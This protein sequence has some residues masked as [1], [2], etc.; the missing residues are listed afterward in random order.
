MH[1]FRDIFYLFFPEVCL[2][3][4]KPLTINEKKICVQCS[5][6]LPVTNFTEE[7]NNLVEQSFYGRVDIQ[8]ASCLFYY[9][10]KSM[11][12]QLVHKLKY[13]NEEQLGTFFGQW[14]GSELAE[15]KRLP[16]IDIVVPVPIH[17]K[18]LKT[19][20]Y[21]Q[22]AKFSQEIAKSIKADYN[23]ENL[24][25]ISDV[26]TQTHKNRADRW[27]N[28][29]EKFSLIDTHLFENKSVLLVDDV[30]T[31]GATI[32]ACALQLQKAKNIKISVVTIAFTS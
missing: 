15:S 6:D 21:N 20:G 2:V 31:T 29:K 19:R 27:K 10:R 32:E 18:K 17:K 14:L 3:C 23:E 28:V 26:A 13:K 9:G 22:V 5:F 24:I 4:N 8:F 30:I 16:K 11:V 1:F 25:C 12:Q 7:A